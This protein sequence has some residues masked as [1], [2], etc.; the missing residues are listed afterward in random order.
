MTKELQIDDRLVT[1]QVGF[2]VVDIV[3]NMCLNA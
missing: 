1:L 3:K 2:F